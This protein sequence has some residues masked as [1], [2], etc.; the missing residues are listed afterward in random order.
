MQVT[1]QHFMRFPHC[2]KKFSSQG[3]VVKSLKAKGGTDCGY[4]SMHQFLTFQRPFLKQAVFMCLLFK[5]FENTVEKE[6]IASNEQF[7]LFPQCFLLV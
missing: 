1:S 7:F 4:K 5:S 6:E 2:F 3:S